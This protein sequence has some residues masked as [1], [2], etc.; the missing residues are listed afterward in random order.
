MNL[1][2]WM[3]V[4]IVSAAVVVLTGCGAEAPDRR[5][6]PAD[7]VADAPASGELVGQGTVLQKG[8]EPAQLCL[9]AVAESY[10]PQCSGPVIDG[11]DWSA[12]EQSESASGVTW[13]TYAVFGTWDGTLFTSTRP[14]VPLSLYDAMPFED[15][16]LSNG[17]S[18]AGDEAQLQRIQQ[19][20]HDAADPAILSSWTAQGFL[21]VSVIHDDGAVQRAM[22][23]R[24]G[25]GL[26]LVQSALRPVG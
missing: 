7:A 26:V 2:T 12:V 1:R 5:A 10:P 6:A 8:D 3:S 11:W 17:A 21:V 16:R 22:D 25:P 18:G 13:G 4:G 24:F 9:G 23:E 14:P 19:E 15:P 20:I